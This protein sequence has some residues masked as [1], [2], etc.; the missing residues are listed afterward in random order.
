MSKISPEQLAQE[1]AALLQRFSP[2][3]GAYLEQIAIRHCEELA[4]HFYEQMLMDAAASQ[5]LTHEQVRQRLNPSMQRWIVGLFSAHD[6]EAALPMVAQ[7]VRIGEVHARIDVPMHLVLR[8]ARALKTRLSR[9]VHADPALDT[10]R[11]SQTTR[12]GFD[13]I[14]MAMEVMSQAY[15]SSHDRNARAEEAYRLFSVAQNVGAERE[16]QRAALLD[17]ENQLMFEQAV[18]LAGAQLPRLGTSEF[19]L[20]FRHKG[21]H[22]FQGTSETQSILDTIDTIDDVL[23][24]MFT[25]GDS[26][27]QTERVQ[28]LR[29]LREHTRSIAFHLDTLFEQHNELESGRD[30]LTRLLN[31]KF[32]PVVLGK[33]VALAR[34]RNVSFAV[35]ALDIDHFKQVNDSHG[36]EAGDMV[37]QQFAAILS[38]CSRAGDYIFRLGGEEFLMLLVDLELDSA[39]RIAEK[40]RKQVAQ[41]SFRLPRDQSMQLSVSI[42]LAMHNG[43]PDYQHTIRLADEALYRAKHQGRNCVVAAQTN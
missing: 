33:E 25:L 14:D 2:E 5:Y 10:A 27:L 22:A 4:N 31:R 8:G 18:N 24:P 17:W 42:G 1:W 6:A 3:V 23:L 38:N 12:L 41:E 39:Q 26:Q 13:L 35:L 30:V 32:L 34:K 16:K 19:G 9:L 43:H 36:H 37:L 21:A 7:Q 15:A 29:D 28:R 40:L 20:W 11:K